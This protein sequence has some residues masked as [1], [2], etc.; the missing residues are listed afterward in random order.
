MA[1][2][3]PVSRTFEAPL[4]VWNLR[5]DAVSVG[6]PLGLPWVPQESPVREPLGAV[7][8]WRDGRF[9]PFHTPAYRSLDITLNRRSMHVRE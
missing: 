1:R 8:A 9:R 4:E 6:R 7:A 3:L 5:H 2:R